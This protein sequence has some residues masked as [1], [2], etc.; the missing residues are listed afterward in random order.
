MWNE[1]SWVRVKISPQK[2][3]WNL[4]SK[5]EWEKL[6][7]SRINLKNH[8]LVW[9]VMTS[10]M[11][12]NLATCLWFRKVVKNP[13]KDIPLCHCCSMYYYAT[14]KHSTTPLQFDKVSELVPHNFQFLPPCTYLG[15]CDYPR[16]GTQHHN[17][18]PR[19][20]KKF[21]YRRKYIHQESRQ[22]QIG[23]WGIGCLDSL[24]VYISLFVSKYSSPTPPAIICSPLCF[25]LS[26]QKKAKQHHALGIKD[27][28]GLHNQSPIRSWCW[29][30]CFCRSLQE[31]ETC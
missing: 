4:A 21:G 24:M 29:C 10:S 9:R 23:R 2:G 3:F 12:L 28:A 5:L 20:T 14:N 19:N 31:G 6:G 7:F 16:E 30:S 15:N 8:H 26:R 27:F 18:A 13:S 11:K 22:I 25:S 17:H 1:T